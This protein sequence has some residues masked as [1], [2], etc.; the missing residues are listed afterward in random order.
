MNCDLKF[1]PANSR[2]GK[3]IK[4]IVK[5]IYKNVYNANINPNPDEYVY[6]EQDG[7]ILAS[8]SLTYRDQKKLFSECYLDFPIENYLTVKGASI[9]VEVGSCI[10]V[11]AGFG[12]QLYKLLPYILNEKNCLFALVTLTQKVQM[13]FSKLKFI[14]YFLTEAHENKV[15]EKNIWGSFYETQP[16]TYVFDIRNSCAK[17]S[18]RD[19]SKYLEINIININKS[20]KINKKI[21][22]HTHFMTEKHTPSQS[23]CS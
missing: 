19:Y 16:R 7:K 3:E 18:L 13:I 6:L 15:P 2:K 10:S 12:V 17:I 1:T 23:L 20:I 4:E 8:F 22:K 14:T 5:R 11:K 21:K 9:S